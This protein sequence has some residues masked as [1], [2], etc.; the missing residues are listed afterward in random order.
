MK[1]FGFE[2]LLAA[3]DVVR[4]LVFPLI[5]LVAGATVTGLLLPTLT[6]RRDDHRKALEV[7][8]ELVADMSEAAM[9]FMVAIQF[10]V[11]GSA[12]QTRDLHKALRS[13]EIRR[14][15]IKTKLDVYFPDTTLGHEW[16]VLGLN[17]IEFYGLIE[18]D[19][20][21][22]LRAATEDLLLKYALVWPGVA[23]DGDPTAPWECAWSHLRDMILLD[24][25]DVIERVLTTRVR[26]LEVPAAPTW[27]T[28]PPRAL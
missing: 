12:K 3:S 19:D 28:P 6:R 7:K 13:W 15:V 5:V 27:I 11:Q 22:R 21:E 2:P 24:Q 18:I 9:E 26:G 14:S 8:T 10:A 4:Y 16:A 20:V 1:L 23:Q 17:M 25:H